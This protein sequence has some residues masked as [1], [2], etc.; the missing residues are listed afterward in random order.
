MNKFSEE[1]ILNVR[2]SAG[3][4]K[5]DNPDITPFRV[6]VP[7]RMP[8]LVSISRE[9]G[10]YYPE[11]KSLLASESCQLGACRQIAE[12]GA[13]SYDAVPA[14]LTQLKKGGC[15]RGQQTN[16][17]EALAGDFVKCCVCTI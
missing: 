5:P 1:A 13:S 3:L 4:I 9:T 10:Q 2:R 12:F 6:Y 11:L 8:P 7:E 17:L 15:L 16:L 14:L